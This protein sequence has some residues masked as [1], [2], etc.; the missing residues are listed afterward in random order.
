MASLKVACMVVMCMT[1][2]G[3][4]PTAEAPKQPLVPS[5]P[6]SLSDV[7]PALHLFTSHQVMP[8]LTLTIYKAGKVL[9]PM[10]FFAVAKAPAKGP[11]LTPEPSTKAPKR[12]TEKSLSQKW[13]SL[14]LGGLIQ[15]HQH[16]FSGMT[17]VL[18]FGLEN[19]KKLTLLKMNAGNVVAVKL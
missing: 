2:V 16:A 15:D 6:Q 4:A 11:S 8:L 3:A 12:D 14:V 10:D 19:K 9:L 17:R 18:S 5:L 7:T 1:V 13:V